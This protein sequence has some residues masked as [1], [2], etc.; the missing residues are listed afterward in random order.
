MSEKTAEFLLNIFKAQEMWAETI[1]LCH[2]WSQLTESV[3]PE[4]NEIR[5]F[6]LANALVNLPNATNTANLVEQSAYPK[7]NS[8][9]SKAFAVTKALF[10]DGANEKAVET[11]RSEIQAIKQKHQQREEELVA[12]FNE[13][14]G[15]S[16]ENLTFEQ[17]S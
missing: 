8:S 3:L 17:F 7:D 4:E 13:T 5:Q 15:K 16:V 11:F 1:D 10:R 6:Y 2:S 12:L 9:V 14:F